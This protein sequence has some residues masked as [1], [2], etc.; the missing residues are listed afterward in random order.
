MASS[1]S[2]SG[3]GWVHS[4]YSPVLAGA[5]SGVRCSWWDFSPRNW[6]ARLLRKGQ[7]VVPGSCLFPF[8][9][10]CSPTVLCHRLWR[11][12]AWFPAPATPA[13]QVVLLL[14]AEA[15]L[16]AA[17]PEPQGLPSIRLEVLQRTFYF[18]F[19]WKCIE[20]EKVGECSEEWGTDVWTR[21]DV[22]E[23]TLGLEL[24]MHQIFL[25]LLSW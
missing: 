15:H 7:V 11:S 18:M 9:F 5:S 8:L 19:Q 20:R 2:L 25:A 24:E 21:E 3:R 1:R 4:Q 6:A 23:A 17:P 13:L 10:T 16:P 22:A 12:W 14:H